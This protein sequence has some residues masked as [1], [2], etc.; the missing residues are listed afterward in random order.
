MEAAQRWDLGADITDFTFAIIGP[1]LTKISANEPINMCEMLNNMQ[2]VACL[3]D[4]VLLK[5]AVQIPRT[6]NSG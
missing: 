5:I 3:E 1:L 6:R 4:V 2:H